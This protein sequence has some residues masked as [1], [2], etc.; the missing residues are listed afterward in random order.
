MIYECK[1]F[2]SK[3]PAIILMYALNYPSFFNQKG[4]AD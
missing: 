1:I 4:Y 2:G 3:V